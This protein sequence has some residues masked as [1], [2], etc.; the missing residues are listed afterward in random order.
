MRMRAINAKICDVCHLKVEVRHPLDLNCL[1]QI[2]CM[3]VATFHCPK[4]ILC[5]EGGGGGVG[6]ASKTKLK[7]ISFNFPMA[8]VTYLSIFRTHAQKE[9]IAFFI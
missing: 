6:E 7:D 4:G 9:D 3:Y 2:L 5:Q 1:L 8:N